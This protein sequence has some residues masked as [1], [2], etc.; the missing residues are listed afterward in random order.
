MLMP[1]ALAPGSSALVLGGLG[2]GTSPVCAPVYMPGPAQCLL[3]LSVSAVVV[4]PRSSRG[5][6][7][8]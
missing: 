6:A 5:S 4:I 2:P 7:L 8:L 3:L 1:T